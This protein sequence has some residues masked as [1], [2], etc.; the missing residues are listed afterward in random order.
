MQ[1]EIV[2]AHFHEYYAGIDAEKLF[3]PDLPKREFGFLRPDKREMIRHLSFYDVS[4]LK[5]YLMSIPI[6]HVYSSTAIYRDPSN[7][8]MNAKGWEGSDMVFEF[9]ADHVKQLKDKPNVRSGVLDGS[10][11]SL[12]KDHTWRLVNDFLLDDF[13][14]SQNDISINFSGNRG[15]HVRVSSKPYLQLS[16]EGRRRLASY[17]NG[18]DL[19]VDLIYSKLKQ[20]GRAKIIA[21]SQ[22][23][24]MSKVAK[25]IGDGQNS[26]E[27]AIDSIALDIDEN[28]LLD[29]HR[30]IRH[31]NTLHASTGMIV[32]PVRDLESFV[33]YEDALVP[34]DEEVRVKF[35]DLRPYS[36]I[37]V[38][39]LTLSE[40]LS[41]KDMRVNRS[42]AVFL[43]LKGL[44]QG[45]N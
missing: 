42:V 35:G 15:F 18:A 3:I 45:N 21:L 20:R 23:G 30:L 9:D 32:M 43:V 10:D 39:G 11:W 28:V 27:E 40:G 31:V 19:D 26:V 4:S 36:G 34:C 25:V 17:I 29:L 2:R 22:P 41:G 37:S 38:G 6:S 5:S 1:E 14:F 33:P 44:A 16:Q 13:G 24:W 12:I 8:D 7:K